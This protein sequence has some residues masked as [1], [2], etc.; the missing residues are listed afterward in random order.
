M[1][2]D[3]VSITSTTGRPSVASGF[4]GPGTRDGFEMVTRAVSRDAYRVIPDAK[5]GPLV[6]EAARVPIS[7]NCPTAITLSSWV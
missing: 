7:F 4:P 2:R 1:E 6:S 3:L 5:P